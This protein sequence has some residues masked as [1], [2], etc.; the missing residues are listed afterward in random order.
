MCFPVAVLW[1]SLD[2]L[3]GGIGATVQ[4]CEETWRGSRVLCGELNE[5]PAWIIP[6]N[7]VA[8][9]KQHS[10]A[11]TEQQRTDG[12]SQDDPTKPPPQPPVPPPPVPPVR[13]SGC[14]AFMLVTWV[15][16]LPRWV[17]SQG[18]L[19]GS[20]KRTYM[21]RSTLIRSPSFPRREDKKVGW[22]TTA[23]TCKVQ[24][25]SDRSSART[26]TE[27]RERSTESIATL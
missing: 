16:Q 6:L 20:F 5:W 12:C 10:P 14:S 1:I 26:E 9:R 24:I 15:G 7:F 19:W 23:L 2:R 25:R 21:K 17:K 8:T 27:W 22:V 11:E 3:N 13:P 4:S 18:N